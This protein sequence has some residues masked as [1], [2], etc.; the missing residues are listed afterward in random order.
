MR[1]AHGGVGMLLPVGGHL[2]GFLLV[3]GS[4]FLQTQFGGQHGIASHAQT[5]FDGQVGIAFRGTH[6]VVGTELV[7]GILAVG[8]EVVGPS[9]EYLPVLSDVVQITV[10]VRDEGDEREHVARLLHWH[11]VTIGLSVGMGIGS[12]IVGSPVLVP[13]SCICILQYGR[14]HRLGQRG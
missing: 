13:S 12:Q 14:Y 3:L 10:K 5:G 8:I 9:G 2:L 4:H 6:E 1:S 7:H 11:S